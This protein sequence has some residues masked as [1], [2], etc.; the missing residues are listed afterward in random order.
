LPLVL[1]LDFPGPP[2][3]GS[4]PDEWALV[5]TEALR[6]WKRAPSNP[7]WLAEAGVPFALTTAKLKDPGVFPE[8]LRAAV[9]AGLDETRALAALTTVPAS[10][11]GVSSVLG[12]IEP[13]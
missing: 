8:R 11:L 5:P 7:R 3:I 10:L 12:S 4:D 9:A 2:R 13:G 6:H 1:P